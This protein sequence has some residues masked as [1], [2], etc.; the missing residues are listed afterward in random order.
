MDGQEPVI[1]W[2]IQRIGRIPTFALTIIFNIGLIAGFAFV[3]QLIGSVFYPEP[4]ID[5]DGEFCAGYCLFITR[6]GIG[7]ALLMV[8]GVVCGIIYGLWDSFSSRY[9]AQKDKS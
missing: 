9:P 2:L 1:V 4:F 3:L 7:V 8:I 5:G 6:F